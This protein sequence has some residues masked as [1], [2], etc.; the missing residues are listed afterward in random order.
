MNDEENF[1]KIE[2]GF[3][4]RIVHKEWWVDIFLLVGGLRDE[5]GVSKFFFRW[6]VVR[7]GGVDIFSTRF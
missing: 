6:G 2:T 4:V 3:S 5:V 7:R 1:A